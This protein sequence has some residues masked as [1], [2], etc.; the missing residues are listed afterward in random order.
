MTARPLFRLSRSYAAQAQDGEWL[1]LKNR[2][3]VLI[4]LAVGFFVRVNE[5]GAQSLWNDEGTSVALAQLSANAILNAAA[6]DIHPPLYYL[7]LSAW[8]PFVGISELAIRFLSVF[9]GVL[10]IAVTFRIAREFFDQDVAVIAAVLSALNPFQTYYAQETRMYIWVTLFAC[11]SV[12]TCVVMFKPP[13]ENNPPPLPKRIRA[14]LLAVAGYVA[15]TLAALYTNYYAFTLVIFQNLA[16]VAWLAWAVRNHRP[17]LGHSIAFWIATQIIIVLA[18]VPWLNFARQSLTSWPGISEPMN[19]WEMG[20]RLLSAYVTGVDTLRDVPILLLVTYAIF[21]VGGLLPSRD[22]RRQSVWGIITCALWAIVPLLAMYFVSLARPAYNPKFLLLATPGFLIVVAR[23]VSVLYPGLFLRERA[24]YASMQDPFPRRLARQYIGIGK[25]FVGGLFAAG[26]V[27]ALQN[28]YVD[29]RLQRDDYR[30]IVNYINAVA[31][32]RDAVMVNAPGQM[33]VVRYYYRG[34]AEIQALPIG[35]PAARDATLNVLDKWENEREYLYAI[36]WATEQADPQ[37]LIE[38]WLASTSFK[39][40]DG[41]HGNVRL[42]QYALAKTFDNAEFQN[43]CF[44]RF[45]DTMRLKQ[46]GIGARQFRSGEFV[47]AVS[48]GQMVP[49]RFTFEALQPP[50][51][52][53]K[54]FLHLMDAQGKLIAQRDYIPVEGIR[55]THLWQVEQDVYDQPALLIPHGTPPG[56]YALW[57]GMYDAE[58]GAR[59]PI[60]NETTGAAGARISEKRLLVETLHVEKTISP[61]AAIEFMRALDWRAGDVALIGYE[62]ETWGYARGEF[63]PLVLYFQAPVKPAMDSKIAIQLRDQGEN[64][65]ASARAFENYPTSRWDE[66]EI[67]RDVHTLVIPQNVLPGEYK[68]VVTDGAQSFEITR[69]QVR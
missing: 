7:L 62:L 20:T 25:L 41:W 10:V 11:L 68:M 47:N 69:V 29:P 33:D 66:N 27:L 12:W 40:R 61:R 28:M 21:F 16:F 57:M 26:T 6:R 36:L 55:P 51:G 4:A 17:R 48:A 59:V 19:L 63:I 5:L 65:I 43:C 54:F 22:L 39:A 44:Y 31:T 34:K 37:Q 42:A 23:G 35:R 13:R 24:A 1:S 32:E 53:Y 14:R 49:L 50:P 18:Y 45:G 2:V 52:H 9:A 46:I 30:G 15:F 64:I 58:T 67:V 60:R 56:E 8:I 3:W 38:T